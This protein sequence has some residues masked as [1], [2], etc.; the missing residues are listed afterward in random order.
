[1]NF[2]RC[3][4]E[5]VAVRK[6]LFVIGGGTKM[7]EVYDSTSQRFTVLK[8]RLTVKG[9]G[10]Y[11][12]FASFSIGSKLFVYFNCSSSVFSY[13]VIEKEW[14]EE[15]CEPIKHLTKFSAIPA[16]RL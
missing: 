13:D 8:Q 7:N 1:M 3:R 10:W 6:K 11:N 9:D 16:S 5:M 4:H 12:V 2:T 14:H 15:S